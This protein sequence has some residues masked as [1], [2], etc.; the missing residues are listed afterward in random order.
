MEINELN[1]E[2]YALDYAEGTL[3]GEELAAMELFL[4]QHPELKEEILAICATTLPEAETVVFEDKAMLLKQSSPVRFLKISF[5]ISSAACLLLALGF[6]WLLSKQDN[7]GE[8]AYQGVTLNIHTNVTVVNSSKVDE[9]IEKITDLETQLSNNS[10][11]EKVEKSII[12]MPVKEERY[13][14]LQL[15]NNDK[16]A[17]SNEKASIEVLTPL[18]SE[19]LIAEG[20]QQTN[21]DNLNVAEPL[22][23]E[24]AEDVADIGDETENNHLVAEVIDEV[25]EADVAV[26]SYP[27]EYINSDDK[28]SKAD[29]SARRRAI[30]GSLWGVFQSS[31]IPEGI[32]SN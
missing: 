2:G 21:N 15:A 31:F 5:A 9:N 20:S 12:Q 4:Q 28:K 11:A 24:L 7:F 16:K 26:K 32:A 22:E 19:D 3:K 10:I 18:E 27:V 13:G 29:K 17:I 23:I 25:N 14:D 8:L 30:K 6:V 1:Y